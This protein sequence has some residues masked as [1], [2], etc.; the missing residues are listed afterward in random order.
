MINTFSAVVRTNQ[1]KGLW[2]GLVP[3]SSNLITNTALQPLKTLSAVE[4][5]RSRDTF[6]VMEKG[7]D[8]TACPK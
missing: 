8:K 3:V 2:R 7:V 4:R 5:K 6:P 1:L